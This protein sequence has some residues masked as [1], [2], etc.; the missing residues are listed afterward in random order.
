M[1]DS[2]A[3]KHVDSRTRVRYKETDQMGIAHHANYIVWFEIGRTD[4]CR[5][6]GFPYAEIERR[7]YLLVVTEV[8]CRF[9]I[10]Y[11]YDEEVL[12]RTSVAEAASRSIKFH[13][14][15]RNGAGDVLH[16][17]GHSSHLWLDRE[18]RKPVRADAAVMKAFEP[19]VS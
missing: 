10:P 12:I 9:K 11:R 2:A 1:V 7:G 3:V 15:L 17:T 16:A 18:T 14:E 13:Y 19:F 6:T 8:S 5:A 4:L